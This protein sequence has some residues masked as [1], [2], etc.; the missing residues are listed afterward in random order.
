M[1]ERSEDYDFSEYP[2]D[3]PYHSTKDKKVV[4]KFKDECNGPL[5]TESAGLRPKMYSIKKSSGDSKLRTKGAEG[6][7]FKK[8][9][10]HKLYKQ[11]LDE[12]K[13]FRH[14]QL[15]IKSHDHQM[16]FYE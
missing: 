9:L 11:S 10:R 14:K 7:L 12:H 13:E 2:I 5:I 16:E 4:G 8:D 6:A 1:Q 3:S 15:A